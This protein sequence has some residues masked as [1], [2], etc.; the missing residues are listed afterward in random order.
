[1]RNYQT[2]EKGTILK[3]IYAKRYE[4]T[5]TPDSPV[6]TPKTITTTTV[7]DKI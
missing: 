3:G 7:Q 4:F 6:P 1:M 2:E 5:S